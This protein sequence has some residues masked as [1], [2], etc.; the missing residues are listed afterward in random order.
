MKTK[1][2]QFCNKEYIYKAKQSTTAHKKNCKKVKEY[3][4]KVFTKEYIELEYILKGRSA[5]EIATE[6]E[7]SAGT[8]IHYVNQYGFKPRNISQ[9]NNNYIKDKRKK[10]NIKRYGEEHNF[11]KNHPSRLKWELELFVN[12]G[13]TNVFQR[14]S[15]K[16]DILPKQLETKYRLGLAVRPELLEENIKYKRLV[17]KISEQNYKLELSNINPNNVERMRNK[18]HLD[19]I[20]SIN[21]GFTNNIPAEIIAHPANLQMLTEYENISKGLKCGFTINELYKRIG[22]YE[23][24]ENKINKKN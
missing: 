13:I 1:M 8:I 20:V 19:H 4:Q 10:T 12:E 6:H 9:S 5:Q 23:Y 15:V 22:Q 11:N 17:Q 24:C 7:F 14:Q 16:D 18:Y 2:C 3:K 21:Y